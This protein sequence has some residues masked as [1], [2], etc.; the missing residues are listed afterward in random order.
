GLLF[1]DLRR[2]ID[3]GPRWL[4]AL[5]DTPTP[6]YGPCVE[7]AGLHHNPTPGPAQQQFLYGHIWVTTAWV[8]R[9]PQWHTQALPLLADLYIRATDLPKSD[10]DRR[11]DFETTLELTASH[12]RWAAEELRGTDL[13]IWFV[14]DGFYGK[15]PVLKEA[16]AHGVI[17]VGRLR[18][19]AALR[20]LP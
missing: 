5:D 1:S 10:A 12:I 14:V 18:C 11:P 17:I 8:V 19:D 13:A 4:M 6:R 2:T 16:R 3:P 15:R 20:D 9:H 7:G